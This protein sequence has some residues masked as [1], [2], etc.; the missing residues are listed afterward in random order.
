MPRDLPVGNGTLLVCF[1][2]DYHIRDLYYPHVG[3]EDHIGGRR[4]R[5]GIW[6]DGVFSWIGA[7][8]EKELRYEK[9]TL[10]T[11]VTLYN[12]EMEILLICR[13]AVD[14]HENIYLRE[15]AI[16]NMQPRLREVR[17]F[18][19]QDFSISGNSV[20]DTAAFDPE[21][22]GVVH[23]KGARYFLANALTAEGAPL[24]QYAVGQKEKGSLEGAFRDAE[25]GIL[26]CNSISQGS[27]DSVISLAL[28][29]G[30]VSRSVCHYWIAAGKSWQEV[31]RLDGRVKQKG[32]QTLITRTGD[33]WSLWVRKETPAL[34]GVSDRV[35][36]LYRRSLL[37]LQTQIDAG[38]GILAANDSDVIQYNRD[39]YSYIWPRDGA[40]TAYA[41]DLAG[42]PGVVRDFYRF[43]ARIVEPGGYLLHKYNPDG[44]PASSWHPWFSNG[45]HQLPIQEDETA[46]VV[47]GLWQHFVLSRDIEF[48]KPLYKPLIKNAADFMA[49]F[50][51]KGTGLPAPSYDLWEERRGILTFTVGAVFGGL[52]AAS[53]FCTVFGETERAERYRKAAAEIRDAA[54]T[55]LWRP[56]LG[57]FCRM[58]SCAGDGELVVDDSCDAS[59][60]GLFAFGMFEAS[61]PKVVA[62]YAVVRE[63]LLV[64]TIGGMAR[65]EGD[66]FYSV[67][68]S[69]P[70]NPW[71]V[72]TLWYADYLVARA[73]SEG[74]MGEVHEI[75]EWVVQH[76]LP[77]GVLPEQL[78]P[79][80]GAPLSVSPL[81]WSH[82][83][84]ISTIQRMIRRS[85]RL[86][87]CPACG[88][89]MTAE[90]RREDWLEKLFGEACDAIH[91]SC[92]V[93]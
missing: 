11:S 5:F 49:G 9:D 71:F 17:L 25:D 55:H 92:R 18:F 60:W 8:W 73:A 14:F 74:E 86:N 19:C 57:R 81:T 78:H 44:T 50:R 66:S 80:T 13:D 54:S 15:I 56:E 69:V 36:E 79:A 75:I 68:S 32:A 22:G 84:F 61:D 37:V 91:G 30:G 7:G 63:R 82:A 51:D 12:R 1:D 64:E 87:T 29:V 20:G 88:M 6:V 23:Y 39:T 42:Y 26:S 24:F 67:D 10:V 70:G 28:V 21:S 41:L 72:A 59:L 33:Y 47:W 93:R 3:Q 27:V 52:T 85:A 31:R 89:P 53:L 58:L 38:G 46:L 83:T 43:I 90:T 65:Y 4:A 48:I 45:E 77:S 16:E 76:A 34:E 35:A 40:L 62:T 2:S